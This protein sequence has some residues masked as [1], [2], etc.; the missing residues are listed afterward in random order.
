MFKLIPNM[1]ILLLCYTF[2]VMFNAVHSVYYVLD[3][4]VNKQNIDY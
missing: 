1:Q 2:K 3:T 4:K